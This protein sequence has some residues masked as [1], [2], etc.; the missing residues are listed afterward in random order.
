M[1][2]Q[3][4]NIAIVWYKRDYKELGGLVSG[5]VASTSPQRTPG[6]TRKK[7]CASIC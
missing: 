4:R 7:T 5:F 3:I 6:P 1:A 2:K